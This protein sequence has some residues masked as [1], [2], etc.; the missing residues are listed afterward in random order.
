[1]VEI[2]EK[3]GPDKVPSCII[4][5][6]LVSAIGQLLESDKSLQ[7]RLSYYLDTK[8]REI[9]SKKVSDF[10]QAD[11]TSNRWKLTKSKN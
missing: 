11:W 5:K 8:R 2:I 6:K 10:T 4:D 3:S 1:M 7:S 9:K